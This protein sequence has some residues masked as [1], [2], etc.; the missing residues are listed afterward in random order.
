MVLGIRLCLFVNEG[1]ELAKDSEIPRRWRVDTLVGHP[2]CRCRGKDAAMRSKVRIDGTICIGAW[3][4]LPI[5]MGEGGFRIITG[6]IAG[7]QVLT[8]ICANR[9]LLLFS[10]ELFHFSQ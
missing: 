5:K 8:L 1:H 9:P 2:V 4:A 6:I 7:Y 10:L 3:A